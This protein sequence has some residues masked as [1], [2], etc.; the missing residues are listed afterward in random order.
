MVYSSSVEVLLLVQVFTMLSLPGRFEYSN[1]D[2]TLQVLT[3][4]TAFKIGVFHIDEGLRVRKDDRSTRINFYNTSRSFWRSYSRAP[5]TCLLMVLCSAFWLIF[6]CVN[7]CFI[8][9][10]ND[11]Y[12]LLLLWLYLTALLQEEK[13]WLNTLVQVSLGS[14]NRT[15]YGE[16][17][18]F[19]ADWFLQKDNYCFDGRK[20]LMVFVRK[21][22]GN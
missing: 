18:W 7:D 17:D 5:L 14:E 21:W 13:K 19:A 22:R 16:I 8:T 3:F 6:Q 12:S 11:F 1:R 2:D 20:R 10:Q 15:L 9:R 4:N